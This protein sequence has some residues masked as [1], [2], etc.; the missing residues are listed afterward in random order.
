MGLAEFLDGL[1]KLFPGYGAVADRLRGGVSREDQD[2]LGA[3]GQVHSL[4]RGEATGPESVTVR[5]R[6]AHFDAPAG[7]KELTPAELAARNKALGGGIVAQLHRPDSAPADV[8]SIACMSG[9]PALTEL[10][11]V[12]WALWAEGHLGLTATR[13]RR[14]RFGNGVGFLWGHEGAVE[15]WK[16]GRPQQHRIGVYMAEMWSAD[17][18]GLVR[19]TLATP[20][21]KIEEAWLGFTTVIA[22]WAWD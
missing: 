18:L 16:L 9:D 15:G 17:P 8:Y 7:W 22:S 1:D 14:I 10:N 4:V 20:P 3:D 2:R 5:G 21:E 19:I 12:R 11:P 6:H 13:M